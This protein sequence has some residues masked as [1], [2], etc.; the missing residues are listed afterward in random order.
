MTKEFFE[1]AA[2]MRVCASS[3]R[4]GHR[5][6]EAAPAPEAPEKTATPPV[7]ESPREGR[8]Y[9]EVDGLLMA[10]PE[11]LP[12]RPE[13]ELDHIRARHGAAE[14]FA[15]IRPLPDH[16]EEAAAE[17]YL[18]LPQRPVLAVGNVRSGHGAKETFGP[19]APLPERE[20]ASTSADLEDDAGTG[21]EA[22]DRIPVLI[23]RLGSP[24]SGRRALAAELLGKR[25]TEAYAAVPALRRALKD[26]ERRVRASAALALGDIGPPGRGV[27]SDLKRASRDKSEDVRSSAMLA[28]RMIDAPR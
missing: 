9:A 8:V 23:E 11:A 5:D 13:P 19:I 1:G 17:E 14:R 3:E 28:L 24:D 2:D 7:I 25:G 12:Q 18:T 16:I 6:V 21:R 20:T 4:S 27:R 26:P 15:A 22:F 10:Y